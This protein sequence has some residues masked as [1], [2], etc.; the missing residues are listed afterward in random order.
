M[1]P[2]MPFLFWPFKNVLYKLHLMACIFYKKFKFSLQLHLYL[3]FKNKILRMQTVFL[4][5]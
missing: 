5:F 4:V 1:M 2:K 3:I